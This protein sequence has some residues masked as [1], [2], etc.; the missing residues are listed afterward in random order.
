M[1][2][3]PLRNHSPSLR[4]LYVC[5]HSSFERK[6]SL[7]FRRH[8]ATQARGNEPFFTITKWQDTYLGGGPD[9]FNFRLHHRVF[10]SAEPSQSDD[11]VYEH[12]LH[13]AMPRAHVIVSLDDLLNDNSHWGEALG[14][15]HGGDFA[16]GLATIRGTVDGPGILPETW[17]IQEDGAAGR[18]L[19]D[20]PTSALKAG[21]RQ[22]VLMNPA[23]NCHLLV[24]HVGLMWPEPMPE[25]HITVILGG[26]VIPTTKQPV[27][28][29]EFRRG[30]LAF[31]IE[32][33]GLV[34]CLP[35]GDFQE[36]WFQRLFGS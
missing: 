36:T 2:V 30:K 17:N 12:K 3:R 34:Q 29:N 28:I 27:F 7:R 6:P 18:L 35:D 22:Q 15:F 24:R 1:F 31:A 32:G 10:S 4:E 26:A 14:D 25:D 13:N 33:S 23:V 11:A 20:V 5:F 8:A 16:T 21:S 19:K 9:K